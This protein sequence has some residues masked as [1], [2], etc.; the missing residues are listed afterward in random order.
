MDKSIK[1]VPDNLVYEG[2][3]AGTQVNEI[4]EEIML[5]LIKQKITITTA[6]QI[7][8]DVADAIDKEAIFGDRRADG[9]I[10]RGD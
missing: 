8:E 6:K 1:H 2:G 9:E 10:I 5:I 7:L 3:I 4:I